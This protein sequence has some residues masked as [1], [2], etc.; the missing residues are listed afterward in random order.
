MASTVSG[1]PG[2]DE[3]ATGNPGVANAAVAN[4]RGGET[5]TAGDE[6]QQYNGQQ[7]KRGAEKKRPMDP[8]S[9][10]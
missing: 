5:E 9:M 10:I 2:E 8:P 4:T 6:I 3:M 7:G 1:E